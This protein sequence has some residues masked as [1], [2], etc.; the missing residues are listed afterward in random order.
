VK[1]VTV[2]CTR[3]Q[4]IKCT[5]VSRGIQKDACFLKVPCLTLRDETEWPETIEAGW[6]AL[7]GAD[8]SRIIRNFRNLQTGSAQHGVFGNGHAARSIPRILAKKFVI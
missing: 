8:S 2:I 6:N 1:V 3:P 4:F 7:V 5:P